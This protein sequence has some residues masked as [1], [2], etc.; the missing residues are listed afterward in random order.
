[1]RRLALLGA[2]VVVVAAMLASTAAAPHRA[3]SEAEARLPSA[4]NP[5]ARGLGGAAA[6]LEA[7]GRAAVVLGPGD[8]APRAGDVWLLVAPAAPLSPAEAQA[9]VAHAA[10]GGLAV[11]ALS[12]RPQ[13]ALAALLGA[14]RLP[15][16]D[17]RTVGG[18]PDH[19]V[20][21][22]LALRAGGDG[23]AS[24]LPGA[25]AV[26]GPEAPP[27]AVAVQVGAGEVLLLA[28][29]EPLDNAHLPEADALSLWVRL[30]ARGRVVFDER[31]LRPRAAGVSLRLPALVGAQVLLAALLLL[32]ALGR[33]HGAIRPPPA[34]G[35]RRTAR[36][37]L[38]SLAA[39]SRRA[40]AEPELAAASWRRLR[41]TLEREAGVAA[42]LPGEEAARRLE[43]RSPAAA[44][45]LRRGEASLH[46][47]DAVL[48]PGDAV[49]RRPVPG[50]LL[51][52]T[53]AAADVEAAL[54]RPGGA[55][56]DR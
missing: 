11:W 56:T 54:R 42:G 4:S 47:G 36:D 27:A 30:A 17:E 35:S 50:Q 40:G 18:L 22:G 13:P 16:R 33:R 21:G 53:R 8:P 38:A 44:A 9:F 15:G 39:L 24:S 29:P 46:G 5:T 6:W 2:L 37:Y 51:E 14:R 26:T 43:G 3:R 31:W 19:P 32:L 12:S 20:L 52:V 34:P 49:L 7:T 45:A 25:R 28:G 1:M 10:R 55:R 41:R 23:V 48:R